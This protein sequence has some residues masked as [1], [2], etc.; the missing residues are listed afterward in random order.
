M[1][2]V[3]VVDLSLLQPAT[4]I[5]TRSNNEKCWRDSNIGETPKLLGEIPE[6]K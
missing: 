3:D 5:E 6:T 4:T 1:G 2:V